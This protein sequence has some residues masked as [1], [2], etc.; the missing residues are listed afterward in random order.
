MRVGL[1]H[2]LLTVVGG[3]TT[4]A[5]FV[6]LAA[7]AAAAPKPPK[8]DTVIDSH[9]RGAH[10]EQFGHV[11]VPLDD[12]AGHVHMQARRRFVASVHESAHV[13]GR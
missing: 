10:D 5:V 7:P 13:Y 2:R 1:R 12:H 4:L 3:L 8:P 11:H 6:A 9:A